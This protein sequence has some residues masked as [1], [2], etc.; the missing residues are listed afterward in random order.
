MVN[1][2]QSRP[3]LK[4]TA[5]G[6]GV[7]GHVGARLLSDLADR[8]GLTSGLSTAMAPTKQRLRGH[9]RGRR[10]SW[11]QSAT[12]GADATFERA[13]EQ[14]PSTPLRGRDHHELRCQWCSHRA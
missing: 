10:P 5:D 14:L 4:V 11:R 7:V 2:N 6:R 3:R 9:D 1:R 8:V 13:A 12:G